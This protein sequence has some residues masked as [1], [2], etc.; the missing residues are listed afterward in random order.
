MTA[1]IDIALDLAARGYPVFPCS[2]TKQPAISEDEG[3]HGFHDASTNVDVVRKLFNRDNAVLVGCP[4]GE[5]TGFDV[6]DIDYRHGGD[7]WEKA[8]QHQIPDTRIHQTQSGG[9]HYLFRHAPG[10]RNSSGR[11]RKDGSIAGIAIGIDVRGQGG[12]AVVPPSDGYSVINDAEIADWP[13]WLLE[14]VLPPPARPRPERTGTVIAIDSKRHAGFIRSVAERVSAAPEGAKHFTLRNAALSLGGI[15]EASGLSDGDATALL[16]AALPGTVKDRRNAEKTIQWGLERGRAKPIELEERPGYLNGRRHDESPATPQDPGWWHSMEAQLGEQPSAEVDEGPPPTSAEPPPPDPSTRIV[17]PPKDWTAPAPLREWVV[18]GWIPRGYVTGLY[19]DGGVGKSL[20]VQQ[21]LT[22]VALGLPWLGLAVKAGRAFGM[23]CEDDDDELHRRQE[24]INAGC[25]VSMRHLENLRLAPRLGFDNL[26]MTFDQSNHPHLTP[27]FADLCKTLDAFPP[28]LVVLDTLADIFGGNEVMRV[29]ARSFVQG[30]GGQIARRWGCGVVIAAH[31]S[32]AGLA[33][34][35]GTS[36]NTAWSNTFRSRLYVTRPEGE[37]D[38][39][40]RLISRMKANY[41]PKG[42]EIAFRWDRGAFGVDGHK[43]GPPPRERLE[44]TQIDAIF[45]EIE[46]AWDVGEAW[47]NAPQSEK[48]GR[49]L[50]LWVQVHHGVTKKGAGRYINEWLAGGFLKAEAIDKRAKAM[51]LRVVQRL[52]P[53][54]EETLDAD[55][56]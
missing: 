50:P 6:L 39:D 8:N 12:Y 17:N 18:E 10:V 9:R 33:T 52:R 37:D 55:Y 29:H 38:G 31:P 3:G 21:L 1:A 53:A 7:V 32:A 42:G 35:S 36:G 40:K 23:M 30:V 45:T 24:A 2:R 5:S 48:Y 26:L 43:A 14:L 15:Q 41:A 47:S 49:Y 11:R 34:G 4:T 56:E 54:R 46:R 25:Q 27:L 22:C 51:G 28:M 20:L 19:G 13:D 44:W 16:L